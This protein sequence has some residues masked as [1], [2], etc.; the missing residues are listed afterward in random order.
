MSKSRIVVENGEVSV[1]TAHDGNGPQQTDGGRTKAN[2]GGGGTTRNTP[3]ST[4]N[5]NIFWAVPP[6]T[7]AFFGR[8]IKMSNAVTLFSLLRFG[9]STKQQQHTH[10]GTLLS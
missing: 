7:S 5:L 8:Y 4:L 10:H 9:K 6:G 1:H 3:R 2:A